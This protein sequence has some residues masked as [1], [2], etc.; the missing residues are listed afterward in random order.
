MVILGESVQVTHPFGI[1]TRATLA[2]LVLKSPLLTYMVLSS[3]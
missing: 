2:F 1:V 3:L